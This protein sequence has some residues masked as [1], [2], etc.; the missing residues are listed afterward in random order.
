M[1]LSI[2]TALALLQSTLGFAPVT[3]PSFGLTAAVSESASAAT[4][5]TAIF[6][7]PNDDEEE[8]GLDLNLEEMFDMFDAAD[9]GEEFDDAIE[10]VKGK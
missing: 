3:S 2:I 1:K 7:E 4:S 9:K 5:T 6:S 8:G 10:K